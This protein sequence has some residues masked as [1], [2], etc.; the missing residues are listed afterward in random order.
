MKLS[1]L[2]TMLILLSSQLAFAQLTTEDTEE[3]LAEQFD[4]YATADKVVAPTYAHIFKLILPNGTTKVLAVKNLNVLLKPAST[5]KLF[6]GWWAYQE[7]ARTDEYLSK[8]LKDSVNT[9]AQNT[10]VKLG[11]TEA[12][13]DYFRNLGLTINNSTFI[14]ADGSGL[15]YANQSNCAVQMELLEMIRRDSEYTTFRNML[16]QPGLNGTL[17]KRL[18]SLKGKVFA[19]TGTLKKT[20]ALSGFIE[21]PQGTIV[22]C[23]LSD[24]LNKTLAAERARIDG[25]VIQNYNKAR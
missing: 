21:A 25:M 12:M 13:K 1:Y 8:M 16:A 4:P 6:T 11:G 14:P 3:F 24:Y 18:T 5:M 22:F 15:S 20:A 23:V 9:M 19:K 2:F 17:K 10:L 7:K